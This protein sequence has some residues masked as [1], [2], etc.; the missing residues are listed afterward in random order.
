M[1]KRLLLYWLATLPT[2]AVGI[3]AFWLGIFGYTF[4]QL[5][6]LPRQELNE[7]K[8]FVSTGELSGD[9]IGVW[10]LNTVIESQ[11][12]ECYSMR[13]YVLEQTNAQPVT[14]VTLPA[15]HLHIGQGV[16]LANNTIQALPSFKKLVTYVINKNFKQVVLVDFPLVNL[17]LA[18]VLK[19]HNPAISITY[20]APPELW[21][22]GSWG[23]D[24]LLKHCCDRIIVLYPHEQ[25]WYKKIGLSVDWLGYPFI[26]EFL[27]YLHNSQ[28]KQPIIAI[29]P[30][31][32]RHEINT[33]LPVFLSCA[34][35]LVSIYPELSFIIPSADSSCH[36]DI[37]VAVEKA[38][39]SGS[40]TTIGT[41]KTKQ[42]EA[43]SRACL[44]L[45][46]PGT[47][48]LEL[49]LLGTPYIAALKLSWL[50][51][52]MFSHLTQ[53]PFIS[54]PNLL[55]RQELCPEIHLEKNDEKAIIEAAERLYAAYKTANPYYIMYIDKLEHFRQRFLE[56]T[57]TLLSSDGNKPT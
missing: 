55:A 21:F 38:N 48:T 40:V 49:A 44:A 6:T 41:D 53:A 31:S 27:P 25:E 57:H 18:Y 23:I 22:W 20:I 3:A 24:K 1:S 16:A 34:K 56:Q 12:A 35:T 19:K 32:R 39:L 11:S 13:E 14:G 28:S 4:Y 9:R 45:T 43:L 37:Q 17:P 26:D 54:L 36:Q 2:L 29:L 33:I 8:V 51:R 5:A 15:E 10:Y 30:G 42:R 47:I 52:F 7:K 50:N 46:K